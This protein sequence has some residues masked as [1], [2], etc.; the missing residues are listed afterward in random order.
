MY[1][2]Q[3]LCQEPIKGPYLSRFECQNARM[4]DV[5]EHPARVGKRIL[6]L[7]FAV[8]MTQDAFAEAVGLQKGEISA[9]ENGQRKPSISKA[10]Q[11]LA[12]FPGITLDWLF[13]E[14][15]WG[16]GQQWVEKLPPF[17][18]IPDQPRVRKSAS[19]DNQ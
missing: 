14:E 16:L 1:L 3:L 6:A 5:P 18:P 10:K 13:L 15:S 2:N 12:R 11:I 4:V 7:R 8:G 9:W 17:S 19:Q